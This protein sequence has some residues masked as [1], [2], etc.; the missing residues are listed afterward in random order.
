MHP[1]ADYVA[2]ALQWGVYTNE[3]CYKLSLPSNATHISCDLL[4]IYLSVLIA[5]SLEVKVICIC[6]KGL[7]LKKNTLINQN[8]SLTFNSCISFI[9]TF[10]PPWVRIAEDYVGTMF[11]I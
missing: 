11:K 4:T 1:M 2:K 5:I 3:S 6:L 10:I 7:L 8:I 9:Y